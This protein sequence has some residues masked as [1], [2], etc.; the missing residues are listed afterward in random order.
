MRR[1]NEDLLKQYDPAL[2]YL[3]ANTVNVAAEAMVKSIRSWPRASARL[4]LSQPAFLHLDATC[5]SSTPQSNRG[6][7][8]IRH[9]RGRYE[10]ARVDTAKDISKN[11]GSVTLLGANWERASVCSYPNYTSRFVHC[12]CEIM[13]PS[14]WNLGYAMS[15]HSWPWHL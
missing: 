15:A 5:I 11:G 3:I 6:I 9:A 4:T 12:I 7:S 14:L 2:L 10:Q 8:A 1:P 13:I